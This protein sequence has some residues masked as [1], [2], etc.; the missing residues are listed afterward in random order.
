MSCYS[1]SLPEL[2]LGSLSMHS[3]S[4][5]V[6]KRLTDDFHEQGAHV[7]PTASDDMEVSKAADCGFHAPV[8]NADEMEVSRAT[9]NLLDS[10]DEYDDIIEPADR[11]FQS[12]SLGFSSVQANYR[13]SGM[14]TPQR[15][16]KRMR[17]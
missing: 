5:G 17:F 7:V 14:R 6:N 12:A 10:D 16:T 1:T 15:P 8:V 2:D 4:Q 11:E 9:D 13:P 3:H